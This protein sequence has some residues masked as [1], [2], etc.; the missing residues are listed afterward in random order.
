M[1]STLI[2]DAF[3]CELDDNAEPLKK[4]NEI[5]DWAETRFGVRNI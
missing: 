3:T 1:F 2:M 5:L 4:Y